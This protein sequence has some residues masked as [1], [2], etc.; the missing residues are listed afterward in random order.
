MSGSEVHTELGIERNLLWINREIDWSQDIDQLMV[1]IKSC[2]TPKGNN[3]DDQKNILQQRVTTIVN[4]DGEKVTDIKT[5]F[6]KDAFAGEGLIL[7]K[8]KKNFHRLIL[9]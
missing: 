5:V 6:A 9:K 4:Y 1:E 8:G 3:S 7:K 2:T